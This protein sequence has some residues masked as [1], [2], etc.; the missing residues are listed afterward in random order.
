MFDSVLEKRRKKMI[1]KSADEK[2]HIKEFCS[3]NIDELDENIFLGFDNCRKL[4]LTNSKNVTSNLT[5]NAFKHLPKLEEFDF[6]NSNI[7]EIN[8]NSFNHFQNLQKIGYHSNKIQRIDDLSFKNM[9]NLTEINLENNQ[10]PKIKQNTFKDL[11]NLKFL[12][13][14]EN[15]IEEIHEKAFCTL[16]NI[17][18]ILLKYNKLKQIHPDLF[19]GLM[20]LR[21]IQLHG[22]LIF[23]ERDKNKNT[24][25][26][27]LY[28]ESNVYRVTLYKL[29]FW[30]ENNINR[31]HNT[32][33]N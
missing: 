2:R 13:L 26:I 24:K 3:N 21:D 22:N 18:Q 29:M 15:N 30:A 33:Y 11:N 16:E 9:R 4:I 23:G 10:I 17:I 6:S 14:S 1:K 19:R 8:E 25:T 32:V 12:N 28:L 20:K 27:G 7:V 5:P 31:I